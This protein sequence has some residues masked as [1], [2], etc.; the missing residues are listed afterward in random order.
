MATTYNRKA[1]KGYYFEGNSFKD[2]LYKRAGSKFL[3][4]SIALTCYRELKNTL[5]HEKESRAFLKEVKKLLNCGDKLT[6]DD[7]G[8]KFKTHFCKS[9]FC[10]VCNRNRA[11]EYINRYEPQILKTENKKF[12]TLSLVNCRPEHLRNNIQY[13][14]EGF[15]RI[16]RNIKKTYGVK[17]EYIKKIEVTEN[18]K[19]RDYHPHFHILIQE[20]KINIVREGKKIT[21]VSEL[22]KTLWLD[23]FKSQ[24]GD[25]GQ[26][27]EAWTFGNGSEL[28]K[29]F[30]KFITKDKKSTKA[31]PIYKLLKPA[32]L[33]KIHAAI[34]GRRIFET[35][36]LFR[37]TQ[38]DTARNLKEMSTQIRKQAERLAWLQLK[39]PGKN[40]SYSYD[41]N[42]RNYIDSATGEFMTQY[43]P[44]EFLTEQMKN[45]R[46][47]THFRSLD[48]QPLQ[49]YQDTKENIF[50]QRGD[51]RPAL[52]KYEFITNE[53]N[54]HRRALY[55]EEM[56]IEPKEKLIE[57]IKSKIAALQFRKI[58]PIEEK[59]PALAFAVQK[60]NIS[61][62]CSTDK[63]FVYQKYKVT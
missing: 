50:E 4:N 43:A 41:F 5:L 40:I 15:Y 63:K 38:A 31:K 62:G 19:R 54:R 3:S 53:I 37:K 20:E 45:Y 10:L 6:L 21:E 46:Y 59:T 9:R 34:K 44:S 56:Q 1:F 7:T 23:Q 11:G 35:T 32:S 2:T 13:M 36:A 57:E 24:A 18:D 26:K 33:M 8:N 48:F 55:I 28:F 42:Q 25:K 58:M 12:I 14:Y 16:R 51:D 47:R 27:I 52:D 49:F 29:Y 39:T 61:L 60:I 17:L 22:L 30:T